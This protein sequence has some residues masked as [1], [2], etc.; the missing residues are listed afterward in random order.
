[1]SLRTPLVLL[2]SLVLLSACT[3][4]IGADRAV[5]DGRG[6]SE[7]NKSITVPAGANAGDL[8]TVNGEIRVGPGARA[9][10][11]ETVNGSIDLADQASVADVETVNGSVRGGAGVRIEGDLEAVNGSLRF[12]PGLRL[13]GDATTVNGSVEASQCEV[14]RDVETVNG[15]LRFDS[16]QLRGAMELV[17]GRVELSGTTVLAGDL[18]VRKPSMG[19]GNSNNKKPVIVIGAGVEVRGR[20]VLEREVDLQI[21][22]AARVGQIIGP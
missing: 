13:A 6:A 11:V 8:S 18:T 15:T 21:D 7:V 3:I 10:D 5:A 1:M 16:C 22:P 9:G 12:G 17:N 19:W 4:S 14:G 2:P 20:I